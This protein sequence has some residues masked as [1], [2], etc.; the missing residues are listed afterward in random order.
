MSNHT[1]SVPALN[2]KPDWRTSAACRDHDPELFFPTG[3]EGGW[4]LVIADA[5]D[6]CRGCPVR[7]TCLQFALDNGIDHGIYGGLTEKERRTLQRRKTAK[8][9]QVDDDEPKPS[10]LREAWERR[11][12]QVDGG[13]L[14]WTG[15]PAV[16][17]ASV[18]HTPRRAAFLITRGTK[19]Q[20]Q[21]LSTCGMEA[22]IQPEHLADARERDEM[23][24][25]GNPPVHP[26]Y[27]AC[28]TRSAY[29]RHVEKGEPI[30]DACRRAYNASQAK[31]TRTG[32]TKAAA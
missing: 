15:N 18:S 30:D 26:R 4:K 1:G 28:G 31:Y 7:S 3:S 10:T 9:Q 24:R 20:G 32:S 6:I 22:C 29:K 8:V 21:V 16:Y 25:A 27:A 17:F 23:S 2:R 19:P 5:K 14:L 11:T 12:K 13:H